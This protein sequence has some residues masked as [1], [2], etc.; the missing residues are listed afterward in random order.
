MTKPTW[1]L[2]SYISI[3][4]TKYLLKLVKTDQHM[5]LFVF[6]GMQISKIKY[7]PLI[8]VTSLIPYTTNDV[9][10]TKNTAR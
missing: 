10:L 8:L 7:F 9:Y 5:I 2:Y 6:L 3:F 4:D 1:K